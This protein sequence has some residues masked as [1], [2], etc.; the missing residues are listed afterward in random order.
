MYFLRFCR[1]GLRLGFGLLGIF[2]RMSDGLLGRSRGLLMGL[3]RLLC[4]L[5]I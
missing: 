2:V 1:I 5:M 4:L 3:D